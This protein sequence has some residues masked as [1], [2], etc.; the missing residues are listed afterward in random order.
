MFFPSY[1]SSEYSE[2][3][4]IRLQARD[5]DLSFCCA[6]F[7]YEHIVQKVPAP[8]DFCMT[9]MEPIL[10]GTKT[11]APKLLQCSKQIWIQRR[12]HFVLSVKGLKVM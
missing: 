5:V 12:L 11:T 1:Y 9:T 4:M 8:P 3:L 7:C 6:H 10:Q 2:L